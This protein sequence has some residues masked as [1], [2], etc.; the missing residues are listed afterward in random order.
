MTAGHIFESDILLTARSG[1]RSSP[2]P[3]RALHPLLLLMLLSVTPAEGQEL[4]GRVSTP[5]GLPVAGVDLDVYDPVTGIKLPASDNTDASGDYRLD[6]ADGVYDVVIQPPATSGWAPSIRRGVTV[7]GRT[8]LDWIVAAAARVLG[9]V[10]DASGA[11][12][13]GANLDFD[14]SDDGS[15]QPVLGDVTSRFGTCVVTV[16][17]GMYIVTIDAP[18]GSPLAPQRLWDWDTARGDT[19]RV[20]LPIASVLSGQV[21]DARN[22][23]VAGGRIRFED[24]LARRLPAWGG[25]TDA[26][27]RYRAGIAPGPLRVMVE[28]PSLSRLVALRTDRIDLTG[29]RSFDLPLADG[30]VISGRVTDSLGR[31]IVGADWDAI[32]EGSGETIFTPGD[33]TDADGRFRMV[34]P[35]GRYRLTLEPRQ[36]NAFDTLSFEGVEVAADTVIDIRIGVGPPPPLGSSVLWSP[37]RNPNYRTAA[38]LLSL[39]AAETDVRIDL[40]DVSGRWV[41]ALHRGGLAAGAHHIEWDGT[42]HHGARAHTGVFFARAVLGA[43]VHVA[44]FILLP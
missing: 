2:R 39:P 36:A 11:A 26:D 43:S 3:R 42:R 7:S 30:V 28:P 6:L 33:N 18:P 34:V 23:P 15:R 8:R 21:R 19:I 5:E 13:E 20:T 12:V 16:E 40:F 14:R 44:R 38:L 17:S 32:S 31:A 22:Q 9:V 4:R 10:R 24:D 29:D 25:S 37:E 41:R 35:A 1:L 27:G